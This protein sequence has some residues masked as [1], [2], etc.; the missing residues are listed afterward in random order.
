[1]VAEAG[2]YP[3]PSNNPGRAR[4]WNGSG[5][6]D[7][8]R[9]VSQETIDSVRRARRGDA[10]TSSSTN[11]TLLLVAFILNVLTCVFAAFALLPLLWMVPMTVHSW[12]IYKGKASSTTTFNV[13]TLL[14]LNLISG[15]LLLIATD[16]A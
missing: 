14:F 3:D 16:N 10:R 2:W 11:Q 7:E 4:Y 12:K 15:V 5:W 9:D 8:Y 6:T 1:M 13:C